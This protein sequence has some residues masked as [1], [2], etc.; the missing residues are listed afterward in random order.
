MMIGQEMQKI[1]ETGVIYHDWLLEADYTIE[2]GSTRRQDIN[3]QID[4]SNEFMRQALP[5]LMSQAINPAVM[6]AAMQSLASWAE[7]NQM[8]QKMQ[9]ALAMATQAALMPPPPPMPPLGATSGGPPMPPPGA[10]QQ[11]P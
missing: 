4:A 8:P 3:Q 11:Q 10:M 2:A 7:V 6:A 5:V 9:E 1:T